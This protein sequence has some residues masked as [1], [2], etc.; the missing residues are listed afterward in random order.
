MSEK[1]RRGKEMGIVKE[2]RIHLYY[3]NGKGKTTAA[4][5]L[6]IRA[7]GAGKKVLIYQF[8]KNNSSS[9]R[10]LLSDLPGVTCLPGPDH[11]KFSWKLSPDE[12][13]EKKK[14]YQKKL[15]EICLLEPKYD[16]LFLDEIL[17]M[18][19]IGFLNETQILE[20]MNSKSEH[21][22]WILTGHKEYEN[23]IRRADYVTEMKKVKHPYDAGI[24]ARKGIEY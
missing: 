3:G 24:A 14:F 20:C 16:V 1:E 9:E 8:L 12:K 2:G 7:A 21:T 10:K 17:D 4:V 22:E 15:E 23:L 13:E 6:C 11:I 18:I 19:S 5:G